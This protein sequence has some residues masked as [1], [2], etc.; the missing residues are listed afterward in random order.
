MFLILFLALAFVLLRSLGGPSLTQSV[1]SPFDDVELGETA[2]RRFDGQRV[3]VTRFASTQRAEL[4]NLDPVMRSKQGV[5]DPSTILCVLIA[6][7]QVPG[8]E[9]RHTRARPVQI[10]NSVPWVGGFVDP[11]N[12]RVFDLLGRAY[13]DGAPLEQVNAN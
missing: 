7:T 3:W 9:I 6:A 4:K 12:G 13:D 1:A 2:L 8:V 10:K 11:S 5:C